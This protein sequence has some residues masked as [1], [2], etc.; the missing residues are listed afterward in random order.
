MDQEQTKQLLSYLERIS[1]ALERIDRQL[2]TTGITTGVDVTGMNAL[3]D[4]LDSLDN[5]YG[6][7]ENL[8]KINNKLEGIESN[9]GFGLLDT[10]DPDDPNYGFL[11]YISDALSIDRE[12]S[13]FPPEK[14]PY[15]VLTEISDTLK[16]IA[17][18]FK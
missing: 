9:L 2:P 13:T 15:N 18:K 16:T 8:E 12:G 10:D 6:V 14:P 5:I 1:S 7:A 3:V 17:E 11:K 4:Q